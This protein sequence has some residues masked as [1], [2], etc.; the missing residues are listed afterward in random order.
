[1]ALESWRIQHVHILMGKAKGTFEKVG[2]KGDDY[3]ISALVK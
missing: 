3:A 2:K 1:M